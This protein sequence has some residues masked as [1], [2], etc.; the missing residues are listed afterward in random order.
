MGF[1]KCGRCGK[2]LIYD[3]DEEFCWYCHAPLCYD[4]WDHFGHCGHPEANAE[5]E[6]A[7]KVTQPIPLRKCGMYW[8]TYVPWLLFGGIFVIVGLALLIVGG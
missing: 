4:C 5:N 2:A 7:R 1:D 8:M 3:D 6:R